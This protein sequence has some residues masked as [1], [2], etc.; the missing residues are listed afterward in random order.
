MANSGKEYEELVRDIQRSLI[1]AGNVPSLKNINIEKN[2]K[3]KDRS[4]IDREFDIYWEFEIGGH[5]YRSVIECK[6]YSSR[7]S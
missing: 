6:D 2:K 4:G 1:N 7:V 5:T 3:I